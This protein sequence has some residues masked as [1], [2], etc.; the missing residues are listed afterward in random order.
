L[1]Q[2]RSTKIDVKRSISYLSANFAATVNLILKISRISLVLIL[3]NMMKI[4]SNTYSDN[5]KKRSDESIVLMPKKGPDVVV[6]R[7]QEFRS[8]HGFC[9]LKMHDNPS[10]N[11]T[12]DQF[13]HIRCTLCM[14]VVKYSSM[15]G[16]VSQLKRR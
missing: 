9:T 13:A 14:S 5:D 2:E 16:A 8:V 4:E 15:K 12:I 7:E 10:I 3:R 1:E 6:T 11:F